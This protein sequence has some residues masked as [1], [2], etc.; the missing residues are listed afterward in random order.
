[1]SVSHSIFRDN[2]VLWHAETA[3][4]SSIDA[5]MANQY[6]RII[7]AMG[8]KAIPWLL[9]ALRD[10]PCI[11]YIVALHEI[12]GERPD[13]PDQDQGKIVLMAAA[14]RKWGRDHGHI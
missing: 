14:W 8:S 12:T 13:F 7:V 10:E 4:M 2:L 1:M 11:H 6:G 3:Y 5:I 9:E